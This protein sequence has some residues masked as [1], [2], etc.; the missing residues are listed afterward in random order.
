MRQRRLWPTVATE[1]VAV[2]RRDVR[3]QR[4]R[5]G[6]VAAVSPLHDLH[7]VPHAGQKGVAEQLAQQSI[8]GEVVEQLGEVLW[9]W[10][11]KILWTSSWIFKTDRMT[12]TWSHRIIQGLFFIA[13]FPLRFPGEEQNQTKHMRNVFKSFWIS[14]AIVKMWG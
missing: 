4:W 6:Q 14:P 3:G 10:R 12:I 5:W 11:N 9:K 1:W 7:A 13:N 8:M 2:L